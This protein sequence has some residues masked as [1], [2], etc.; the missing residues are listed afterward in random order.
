VIDLVAGMAFGCFVACVG[1]RRVW[2]AIG[3]LGITMTWSLAIRFGV[4]ALVAHPGIVQLLSVVTVIVAL[5]AV[6]TE[7]TAEGSDVAETE[8]VRGIRI[9]SQGRP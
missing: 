1:S 6:W 2:R 5:D 7:W 8:T 3:Y 9:L 4:N